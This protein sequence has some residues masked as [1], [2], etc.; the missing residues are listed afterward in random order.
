MTKKKFDA[1][2]H[3]KKIEYAAAG[4]IGFQKITNSELQERFFPKLGIIM[5][6]PY[7][8]RFGFEGYLTKQEAID[9]AISLKGYYSTLLKPQPEQTNE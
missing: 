7:N 3:S 2:E 9:A 4:R 8:A 6:A 1:L 5:L